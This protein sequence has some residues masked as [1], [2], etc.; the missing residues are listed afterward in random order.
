MKS[1]MCGEFCLDVHP[2]TL[3]SP[4]IALSCDAPK[5]GCVIPPPCVCCTPLISPAIALSCDA[6]KGGCMIPPLCVLYSRDFLCLATSHSPRRSK[7][8]WFCIA[9]MMIFMEWRPL[10]AS[11]RDFLCLATSHSPR[12]SKY[13]WFCFAVIGMDVFAASRLSICMRCWWVNVWMPMPTRKYYAPLFGG[14]DVF[15]I[16]C[17]FNEFILVCLVC[18]EILV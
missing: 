16:L 11:P 15:L 9:F 17:G 6:L 13:V 2:R 14:F 12:R 10:H 18:D 8:V 4:A 5:G 3:I 1:F 7:C